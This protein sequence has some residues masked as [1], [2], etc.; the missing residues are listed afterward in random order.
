MINGE[1]EISDRVTFRGLTRANLFQFLA[2]DFSFGFENEKKAGI[3]PCFFCCVLN[4]AGSLTTKP[5]N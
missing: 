5:N 2:S 3:I 4:Q 1:S